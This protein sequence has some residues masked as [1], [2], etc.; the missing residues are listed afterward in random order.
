MTMMRLDDIC[1]NYEDLKAKVV[2]CTTNKAEQA[3]GG[4]KETYVPMEV[5]HASSNEYD[6]EDW[7]HVERRGT[8]CHDCGT[9]G[10][11]ARY[12][13]RKGK[14]KGKGRGGGKE[15]V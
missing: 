1:E 3:R 10:H 4:Q 11:L 6:E 15:Y 2:S 7:R 8:V 13:W 5:D 9:M 12:R 14:G